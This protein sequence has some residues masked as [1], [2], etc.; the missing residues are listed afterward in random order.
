M[1]ERRDLR[2]SNAD[3]EAVVE[4]L[5]T[6]LG[7]GRLDF[8]EY[9]DRIGRAY[10]STTYGELHALLVD[11]PCHDLP[12]Q[13]TPPPPPVRPADRTLRE[14][15]DDL[16]VA[17]KILWIVWAG[18]V[19]TNLAVWAMLSIHGGMKTFWPIWPMV[20]GGAALLGVSIGL[21]VLRRGE[22]RRAAAKRRAKL[23]RQVH[24]PR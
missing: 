13:P 16:P 15:A 11:L 19:L 2:V 3:R 6:A 23:A 21:T 14:A 5:S 4:A 20:P 1:V 17:V 24:R 8:A 10:R 9:D 7:E 12:R 22:R 18:A